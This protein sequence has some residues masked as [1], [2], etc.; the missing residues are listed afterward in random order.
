MPRNRDE[1]GALLRFITPVLMT[2]AIFLLTQIHTTLRQ[3]D[4]RVYLHQTN[5]E[6]HVTRT[7][8]VQISR[9]IDQLRQEIL[10][11]LRQ[12]AL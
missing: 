8:W 2:I 6:L 3:L 7:E 11:V 5:A 10:A 9:Q 4:Q 12:P 1:W